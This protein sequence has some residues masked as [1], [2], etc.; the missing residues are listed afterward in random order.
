MYEAK[1]PDRGIAVWVTHSMPEDRLL[2]RFSTDAESSTVP[3]DLLLR[4]DGT[5]WS[6]LQE[7]SFE[8]LSQYDALRPYESS[9]SLLM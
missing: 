2:Y 7:L 8:L 9:K 3:D 1:D 6:L 4:L 5:R